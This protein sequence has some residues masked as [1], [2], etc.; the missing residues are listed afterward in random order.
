[1]RAWSAT[2][3]SKEAAVTTSLREKTT[4]PVPSMAAGPPS[5]IVRTVTRQGAQARSPLEA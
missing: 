2:T 5:M 4:L 1:M 3:T